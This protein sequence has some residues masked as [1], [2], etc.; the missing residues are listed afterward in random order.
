MN[1]HRAD[2]C[3]QRLK[4][5][6]RLARAVWGKLSRRNAVVLTA[7]IGNH[8]SVAMGDLALTDG[9]WYVT[10]PGLLRI[11]T[12][13]LD[14]GHLRPPFVGKY[15]RATGIAFERTGTHAI[16]ITEI[17]EMKEVHLTI[18]EG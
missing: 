6:L 16:V 12:R 15:V 13:T 8:L 9:R 5:E 18:D 14:D 7:L 2:A 17:K 4:A 3:Q 10:H 1:R 11:V